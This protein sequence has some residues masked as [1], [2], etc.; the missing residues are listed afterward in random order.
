[1]SDDKGKGRRERVPSAFRSD[2]CSSSSVA[3]FW[4][5]IPQQ[6]HRFSFI[7]KSSGWE[8]CYSKTNS[9]NDANVDFCCEE[10]GTSFNDPLDAFEARAQE[11]VHTEG[12]RLCIL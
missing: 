9:L 6:E 2:V 7:K 1:M 5:A 3:G 8:R 11:R 12:Q 10:V 4:R